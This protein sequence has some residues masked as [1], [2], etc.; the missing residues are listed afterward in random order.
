M[1]GINYAYVFQDCRR[2]GRSSRSSSRALRGERE[3]GPLQRGNT[4]KIAKITTGGLGTYNRSTGFPSGS[5]DLDWGDLTFTMDRGIELN[6]DA[7][8]RRRGELRSHRFYGLGTLQKDKIAPEVDAYRFS[9]IFKPREPGAQEPRLHRLGFRRLLPDQDHIKATSP[10]SARNEQLDCYLLLRRGRPRSI[11]RPR[12]TAPSPW[13]A[14]PL[15]GF[16]T[17]V[18]SLDGIPLIRVPTARFKSAFTFSATDGYSDATG[19]MNL[20][21]VIVARRAV[22]A[23]VKT[24]KVRVFTPEQNQDADAWKIQTRKYHDCWVPDNKLSAV[25]VN[26]ALTTPVALTGTFAAGSASNTTKCTITGA[27]AGNSIYYSLTD[28]AVTTVHQNDVIDVTAL[29]AY[30]SGANTAATTASQFFNI[31]EL[32]AT[33]HVVRFVSHD[34][35][36]GELGA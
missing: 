5:V 18:K 33:K 19:T 32:D 6:I 10:S 3:P 34:I 31:Y 23:V 12:S 16:T 17:E 14:S 36:S 13:L 1:A 11:S 30:V 8:G 29:T 2:R 20:N 22:I 28:A 9:A 24:D 4:I 35:A 26:Y 25:Y 7:Q 15:A 21:W 27:T